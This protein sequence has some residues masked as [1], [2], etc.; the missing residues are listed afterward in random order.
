MGI[1]GRVAVFLGT[2]LAFLSI[3]RCV[4]STLPAAV[5]VGHGVGL[6]LPAAEASLG[7]QQRGGGGSPQSLS[8]PHI[9]APRQWDLVCSSRGLKQL[10]QSLYMAG[11][12][13]GGIVFGGLS[14][15]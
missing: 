8:H 7:G 9:L 2:F 11:V 15:R 12:L 6:T 1:L 14:D 3:G 5:A 10:A 13:V 4:G